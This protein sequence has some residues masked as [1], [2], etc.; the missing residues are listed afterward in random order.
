LGLTVWRGSSSD[1]RHADCRIEIGHRGAAGHRFDTE[2]FGHRVIGDEVRGG[3]EPTPDAIN[4]MQPETIQLLAKDIGVLALALTAGAA[5]L[6][7][8]LGP[9]GWIVAGV[10][11]RKNQPTL[12]GFAMDATDGRRAERYGTHAGLNRSAGRRFLRSRRR[13]RLILV[14]AALL[15]GAYHEPSFAGP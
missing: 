3:G 6:L 7:A 2:L 13:Q 14:T 9:A 8:V 15:C 1:Q 10:V 5:A 12:A 4:K 11:A